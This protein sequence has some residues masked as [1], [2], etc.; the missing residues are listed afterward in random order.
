[1]FLPF[2]GLAIGL[3][4]GQAIDSEVD[5]PELQ[6]AREDQQILEKQL[7]GVR[8]A[9]QT[10]EAQFESQLVSSRVGLD[11]KTR[12]EMDSQREQLSRE[13]E[14]DLNSMQRS[15]ELEVDSVQEELQRTYVRE[16][17]GLKSEING[18]KANLKVKKWLSW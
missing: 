8:V 5:S 13:M 15:H 11:T 16:T 14:R 17:V 4:V 1:M 3:L 2:S 6:R 18:M 12:V 9:A 10:Q 7:A